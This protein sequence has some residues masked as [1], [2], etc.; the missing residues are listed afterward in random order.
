MEK[1]FWNYFLGKS[2]FGYIKEC[3]FFS[4]LIS[5]Q[6]LAGVYTHILLFGNSFLNY[7]GHLLHRAFWQEFFC[8]T[9]RLHKVLSV[10]API[11]H[12]MVWEFISNCTHI[13]YTKELFPNHLCNH[14]GPHSI[15][16][17]GISGG[18]KGGH[19]KGG[20]LKMGLRTDIRT[21]HV[22]F[23]LKFALDMSILTALSKA[24]P[25]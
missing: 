6:F 17:V 7:T 8:V 23:A 10:N 22:D 20:H 16:H 4:E 25:G 5:Q 21:R 12:K 14:F 19:L 9:R 15:Q 3:V 1:L 24:T 13:C 18:S 11:T 2:H